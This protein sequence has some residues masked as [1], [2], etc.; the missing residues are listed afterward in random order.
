MSIV[1]TG[2][3]GLVGSY[4]K[5]LMPEAIY[6]SSKDYDLRD[7]RQVKKLFSDHHASIVIHLAAHVGGFLD[8]IDHPVEF[9]EE[10]VLMNTLVL[11][12]SYRHD[13]ERFIGILSTCIYPDQADHYPMT[14]EDLHSGPPP[15]THFSYGYAKR[16]LAVQID[17]YNQ[18]FNTRY[19]YLNPSNLYGAFDKFDEKRSHFVSALLKKIMDAE[20]KGEKK[21]MLLGTGQ[22]LRQFMYAG[23]LALCIK[24][25]IESDVFENLNVACD[26]NYSI[27]RI[28]EI[29]LE[30]LGKNDWT[31]EF[32]TSKPDG[33][34]RKDVSS[35]KLLAALP[36][37]R[38]TPLKD[39]LKMTYEWLK[40]STP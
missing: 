1:V 25:M 36:G 20:K 15:P 34:F 40:S 16:C 28:A 18:Q 17:A 3:S 8:S 11:R 9:F 21:I 7:E 26:E 10:N 6:L 31:I 4:L 32:D 24:R 14:E 39:G 30:A 13:V 23:D 5:Q 29:A 22:P 2:G 35:A 12:E 37:F 33:Q 19:N 38:F 27:R